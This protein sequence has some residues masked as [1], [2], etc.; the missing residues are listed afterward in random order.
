MRPCGL[1]LS[2]SRW[3]RWRAAASAP[4][5][6]AVLYLTQPALHQCCPA[7]CAARQ[8]LAWPAAHT[9]AISGAPPCHNSHSHSRPRKRRD[10]A[11]SLQHH[12]PSRM[13]H[14]PPRRRRPCHHPPQPLP[15]SSAHRC[16]RFRHRRFRH[17]R[18]RRSRRLLL[19]RLHRDE[20]VA[21]RECSIGIAAARF[22]RRV[23]PLGR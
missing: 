3:R 10:H 16:R 5:A 12:L 19:A 8:R 1:S 14:W 9:C 15:H 23:T 22:D 6:P 13:R 2:I 20:S 7:G 21:R 4:A 18:S 11:Q 17:R